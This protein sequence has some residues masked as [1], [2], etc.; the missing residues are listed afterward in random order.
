MRPESALA[1]VLAADRTHFN[2]RVA[3]TRHRHAGFDIEGFT[4]FATGTLADVVEAV[5]AVAPERTHAVT[6]RA[7]DMALELVAQGWAGPTARTPWLD[8]AWSE[9]APV[10]A[11][12]IAD[13]PQ[14]VLASV[15]NAVI[16]LS[17]WPEVRV[18]EWIASMHP[19]G[20]KVKDLA[21]LR[22]LGELLAWRCGMAQYRHG[23]LQAGDALS[24]DLALA[25]LGVVDVDWPALRAALL[26]DPWYDPRGRGHDLPGCGRSVGAF[27]GF[28]GRFAQPPELRA[29]DDGFLVRSAERHFL[30][31]ADRYGAVLLPASG[32]AFAAAPVAD[33][34][35]PP[36]AVVAALDWPVDAFTAVC[37]A[38]TLAVCTPYSHHVAVLP[39]P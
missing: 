19:L 34:T 15:G 25:A 11:R 17:Q 9:L 30:L 37:N 5:A 39:R 26:A 24:P 35:K 23:A 18:A 3:E 31:L 38:H 20:G 8:R 32:A 13:H 2:Q 6:L 16:A 22:A 10:L 12:L 21:T 29:C 4:A 1:R 14:A 27:I 28:G 7:W 33:G 36:P